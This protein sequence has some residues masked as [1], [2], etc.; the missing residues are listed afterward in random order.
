MK[1]QLSRWSGGVDRLAKGTELN[2][3]LRKVVKQFDEMPERAAQPVKSP[4]HEDV[5]LNAG[6]EGSIKPGALLNS[7]T[8]LVLEDPVAPCLLQSTPL[9]VEV[10]VVSGHARIANEHTLFWN[11]IPGLASP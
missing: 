10:L 1:G 7:S 11:R 2:T 3:T 9:K 5:A 4:D 6:S 8:R